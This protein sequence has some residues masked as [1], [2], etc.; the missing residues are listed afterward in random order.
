MSTTTIDD[1]ADNCF[2]PH[3]DLKPIDPEIFHYC[4][5][6]DRHGVKI[7]QGNCYNSFGK[8]KQSITLCANCLCKYDDKIG[9]NNKLVCA[10]KKTDSAEAEITQACRKV[11]SDSATTFIPQLDFY[12]IVRE[13]F[14]SSKLV[15][16]YFYGDS[17]NVDP[18]FKRLWPVR[19]A[20][21]E[22]GL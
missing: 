5:F 6:C 15:Q 2:I 3:A 8:F 13:I 16:D 7:L 19:Y 17:K 20:L 14:Q 9:Y 12:K 10:D 22:Y 18:Q 4:Q 11:V 1:I 21:K